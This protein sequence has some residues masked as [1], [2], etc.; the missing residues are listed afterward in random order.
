MSWIGP[1]VLIILKQK[2]SKTLGKLFLIK[3]L[4]NAAKRVAFTNMIIISLMKDIWD[5]I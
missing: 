3:K 2:V 5:A 1:Q 4:K